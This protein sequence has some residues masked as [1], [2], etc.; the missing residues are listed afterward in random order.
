MDETKVLDLKVFF[1]SEENQFRVEITGKKAL[2]IQEAINIMEN[3][4]NYIAAKG[5][6]TMGD[7]YDNEEATNG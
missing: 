7:H 4:S 1:N 6:K 2:P 3:I 5:Y